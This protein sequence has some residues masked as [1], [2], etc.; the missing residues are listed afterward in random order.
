M[1]SADANSVLNTFLAA[2]ERADVA[3]VAALYAEEATVWHSNDNITQSKAENLR[4]LGFL[5]KVATLR[6]TILERVISG[7][8]VAQR[9]RVEMIA[10]AN[11]RSATSDAAIFFTIRDGLIHR[12][13]EYIDSD[14]VRAIT[15]LFQA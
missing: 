11:G 7:E 9:H 8:Q 4:T 3:A 1:S 13:D 14:S 6:Y 2:I 12:I 15:A 10:R 5:T